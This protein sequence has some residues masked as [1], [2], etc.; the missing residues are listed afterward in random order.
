[1]NAGVEVVVAKKDN[2]FTQARFE[3][4]LFYPEN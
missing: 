1:M 3:Q 2:L 4:K